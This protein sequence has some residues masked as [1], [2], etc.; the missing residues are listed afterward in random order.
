VVSTKKDFTVAHQYISSRLAR[1]GVLAFIAFALAGILAFSGRAATPAPATVIAPTAHIAAQ[2]LQTVGSARAGVLG[3]AG[4]QLA[5]SQGYFA[6]EGVAIDFVAVDASTV[7]TTVI[8]GG[9][10]VAGL[11]LEVGVFSAMLR[12][13]EFRIVAPQANSEPDANGTFFVVRKDL[14]DTGRVHTDADLKGLKIAVPGHGPTQ[15]Y[16]VARAMEAG[17][18]TL[19]DAEVV[20]LGFPAMVTALDK[21]AID[22]A[23]L[24]EPQATIAV[25][26]GSGV[27]WKG[28]ADVVPGFQQTVVIFTPQFA[29]QRDL[30]T[31]WT[32]AYLR[33]IREYNDAFRKNQHRTE[34]VESLAGAFA[35]Q[36]TLFDGMSLPH[37]NPD[38]KMNL[39]SIQDGMRWYV[40]MGYLSEPVDLTT[41]VD[42]SFVEAAVA[43]LG[44]YR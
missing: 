13:V 11:G 37:L 21:Q 40:E 25:E 7:F 43:K 29:A 2:A 36:P 31:R 15:E 14:I 44:A 20:G 42:S 17:G 23:L 9:V 24:P 33:G 4:Q 39:T 41:A 35:I 28:V 12:G 18:L 3:Q 32:T 38:G 1:T 22:V 16:V 6:E 30:A 5:E 27:K 19:T 34:T 8:S 26:N 10:D